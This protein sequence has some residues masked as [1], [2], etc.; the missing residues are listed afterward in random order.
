MRTVGVKVSQ[1]LA[2]AARE[3]ARWADRSLAG[4]IEHWARLG[5]SVEGAMSGDAAIALKRSG[6]DPESVREDPQAVQAVMDAL[7]ALRKSMPYKKIREHIARSDGPL[8]E[9]DPDDPHGVVQVM[10]DGSRVRGRIEDRAFVPS[11]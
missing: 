4:Q 3:T 5:R 8:Y 7:D 9:V 10:P 2:D 1:E 11:S 6:G